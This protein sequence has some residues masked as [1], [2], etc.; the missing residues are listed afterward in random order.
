MCNLNQKGKLTIE[1]L[2]VVPKSVF[3]NNATYD[4]YISIHC[5]WNNQQLNH[6]PWNS[7]FEKQIKNE[8]INTNVKTKE[9]NCK[10][11]S[12]VLKLRLNKKHY[13]LKWNI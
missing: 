1:L 2:V 12:L 10:N 13:G 9:T 6:G 5:S 3:N 8:Q 4:H 7:M 11:E